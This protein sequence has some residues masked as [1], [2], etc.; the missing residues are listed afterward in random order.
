MNLINLS[1][2]THFPFQSITFPLRDTKYTNSSARGWGKART[3]WRKILDTKYYT[4][5]FGRFQKCRENE[6]PI[7]LLLK[8][9]QIP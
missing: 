7:Y 1:L 8:G 6:A 3:F 5:E 4:Y 2:K 9:I